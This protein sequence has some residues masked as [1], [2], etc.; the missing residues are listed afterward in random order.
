MIMVTGNMTI[1]WDVSSDC[2]TLCHMLDKFLGIGTVRLY[3]RPGAPPRSVCAAMYSLPPSNIITDVGL[4]SPSTYSLEVYVYSELGQLNS[5]GATPLVIDQDG[6]GRTV[7][8]A[9]VRVLTPSDSVTK[10]TKTITEAP[11]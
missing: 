7:H 5:S 8:V 6:P 11:P 1:L 3:L 2:S 10:R 9:T 4:F